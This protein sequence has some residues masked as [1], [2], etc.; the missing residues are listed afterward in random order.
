MIVR[1]PNVG[2][3]GAMIYADCGVVIEPSAAELAEIAIASADSCRALIGA[4]PRVAMLSF[5]TKGSA[6]HRL[7]D[8]VVELHGPCVRARPKLKSMANC[9]RTP[10]SCQR[11]VNRKHPVQALRSRQRANFSGPPS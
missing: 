10:H 2:S 6:Q 1:D 11:S 3:N 8:K 9:K 4:E 7:I 5:S